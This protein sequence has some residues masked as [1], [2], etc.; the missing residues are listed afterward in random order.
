[1]PEKEKTAFELKGISKS[2]GRHQVLKNLSLS[3]N[4]GDFALLLGAN[5]SG[6]S[7]LLRLCVGLSRPDRGNVLFQGSSQNPQNSRDIGHAGHSLFVYGNLTVKENISLFCELMD[8]SRDVDSYLEEWQLQSHGDKRVF[9][10]SKGLQFRVSLCRAF[11]HHPR[12]LFLDEPTSSLDEASTERL[13][14][15]AKECSAE[16]EKGGFV[17]VATHDVKRLKEHANRIMVLQNGVITKDLSRLQAEDPRR[18][19]EELKEEVIE[20]YLE[21][22]R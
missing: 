8:I 22:N 1:M 7:T 16:D 17:V 6:K 11:I 13:I 5:G 18:P 2:F 9:E 21:T 19:L 15:K 10:L 20:Y 12:F 14:R 4:Q 3:V